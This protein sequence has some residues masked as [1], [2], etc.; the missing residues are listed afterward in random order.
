M[1]EKILNLYKSGKFST[2]DIAEKTKKSQRYVQMVIESDEKLVRYGRTRELPIFT[3]LDVYYILDNPGEIEEV[4]QRKYREHYVKQAKRNSTRDLESVN[5]DVARA[6]LRSMAL[7]R[8]NYQCVECNSS[9]CLEVHHIKR[10][11]EYPAL[12][13]DINNCET[14]CHLCHDKKLMRN[15][16]NM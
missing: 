10:V 8:D 7:E 1:K 15:N 4:I 16:T 14:R 12:E 9:I 13:R 3:I 5:T 11:S 2:R 6:K